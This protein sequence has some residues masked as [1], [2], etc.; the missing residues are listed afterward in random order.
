MLGSGGDAINR[1][2]QSSPKAPS[3][4]ATR[5]VEAP[6]AY[7]GIRHCRAG[8]GLSTGLRGRTVQ[9]HKYFGDCDLKQR[10]GVMTF[11]EHIAHR[12]S[13]GGSKRRALRESMAD[14]AGGVQIIN[15]LGFD[16][17]SIALPDGMDLEDRADRMNEFWRALAEFQFRHVLVVA[18]C[19]D[20]A[21]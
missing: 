10:P 17:V 12:L 14:D 18:L 8:S 11:K 6:M 2:G 1:P 19:T 3:K 9:A 13:A 7:P 16:A 5:R 15:C 20:E 21:E 4:P